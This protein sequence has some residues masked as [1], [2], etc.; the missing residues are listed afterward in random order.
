[1]TGL[2]PLMAAWPRRLG[3]TRIV[4]LIGSIAV[5]LLFRFASESLGLEFAVLALEVFDFLFQLDKAAAGLGMHALPVAGL[6]PQFEILA[7]QPCHLGP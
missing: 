2:T 1:M 7:P 3:L 4:E 5:G 6:L